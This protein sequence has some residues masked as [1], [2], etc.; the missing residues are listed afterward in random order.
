MVTVKDS[1]PS[2]TKRHPSA[3]IQINEIKVAEFQFLA[4][5]DLD[6]LIV[7]ILSLIEQIQ[8]S[9]LNLLTYWQQRQIDEAGGKVTPPEQ[10][11]SYERSD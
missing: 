7:D 6:R 10:R 1:E 11:D 5:S 9:P 4:V 2:K 3:P 8:P